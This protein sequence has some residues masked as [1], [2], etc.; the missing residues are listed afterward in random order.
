MAW[1]VAGWVK[2]FLG[3]PEAAIECEAHAM[4]LSPH[5]PLTFS[6]QAGIAAAHLFAGRYAEALSWAE[7]SIREHPDYI[8]STSVAV[9]AGAL[10]GNHAAATKAMARLRQLMPE[11]RMS[12]LGDL[13]P[14][15]RAEDFNRWAEGLRRA[16]LP[17]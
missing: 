12:N 1:W 9:A 5:D 2:V 4:R 11:L 10:A 8:P 3:E 15:R 7:R 16:G 14:I 17:E 13:F 6:M